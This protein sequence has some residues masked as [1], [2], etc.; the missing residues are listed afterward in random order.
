MKTLDATF[1][2]ALRSARMA[3]VSLKDRLKRYRAKHGL[4]QS[5]LARQLG[6]PLKTL[7]NWEIE[8]TTPSELAQRALLALLK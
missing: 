4:S 2:L 7:Q 5:M 8:R 6:V 1:A 3:K